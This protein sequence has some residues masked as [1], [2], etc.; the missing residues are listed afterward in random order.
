MKDLSSTLT[1]CFTCELKPYSPEKR[2]DT[3]FFEER[4][5][6]FYPEN[7]FLGYVYICECC[8]SE[9]LDHYLNK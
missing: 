6:E 5:N 1:F 7:E 4:L 2:A 8:H 9:L 3:E